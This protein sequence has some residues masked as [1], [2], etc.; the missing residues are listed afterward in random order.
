MHVIATLR[1]YTVLP[2]ASGIQWKA[3]ITAA[4]IAAR[5]SALHF[6]ASRYTSQI[7]SALSAMNGIAAARKPPM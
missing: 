7:V 4:A 1:G 5:S 2:N 6:N 3:K